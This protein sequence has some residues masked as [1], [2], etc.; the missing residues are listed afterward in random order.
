MALEREYKKE[1]SVMQIQHFSVNDGD[2]IRTTVF[3]AGC[4]LHCIWCCNPENAGCLDAEHRMTVDEV[5]GI[6]AKESIF[7]RNGHGGVT[8]SG[9]EATW[10]QGYLRALTE[11][12]YDRGY[13]LSIETCGSFDFAGV[14]DILE[15]MDLIFFDLKHMDPR[16]HRLFTGADNAAILDNLKKVSGL[17]V[18]LVVRIPVIVGVNAYEE[19]ILK[20][21]E[22][23]AANAPAA[24]LELLPYHRFGADKYVKLGLPGPDE[25]YEE[26]R[27]ELAPGIAAERMDIPSDEMLEHF[28]D[29]AAAHGIGRISFK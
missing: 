21:C 5:V 12:L 13:S 22:F 23:I 27:V 29:I 9:G 25:R 8:F 10:Q 28:Y 7:F 2:G 15:K 14:S 19:N 18:R 24:S 3:L 26:L 16:F 1:G 20:T 17:G 4:P 11:Q 6:V